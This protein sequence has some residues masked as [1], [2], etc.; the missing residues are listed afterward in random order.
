MIMQMGFHTVDWNVRD[1]SG[2]CI[3]SGIYILRIQVGEFNAVQ[4]ML[5]V[6]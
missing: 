2:R 4:K 6:M 1:L 5:M 3:A